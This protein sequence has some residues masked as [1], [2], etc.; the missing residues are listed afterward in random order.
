LERSFDDDA[1]ARPVEEIPMKRLTMAAVLALSACASYEPVRESNFPQLASGGCT[2]EGKQTIVTAFVNKA[3]ENTVVL[4]D[5]NDPST[6]VPANLPRAGWGQR[7]RNVFG[8]EGKNEVAAE[9]LNQ[10]AHQ[11][12]PVT[13]TLECQGSNHAPLVRS[14]HYTDQQ[15]QRVAIGY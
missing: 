4:W 15:G 3:Y 9:Q 6:T 13:F 14:V 11:R 10:V 8:G 1:R 2:E 7:L 12:L 5:G